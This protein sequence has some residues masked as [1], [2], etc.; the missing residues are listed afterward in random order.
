MSG[1]SVR[2]SIIR[3]LA[4]A[5]LLVM[6]S[7]C[8][9]SKHAEVMGTEDLQGA[10]SGADMSSEQGPDSDRGSMGGLAEEEI[11][12]RSAFEGGAAGDLMPFDVTEDRDRMGGMESGGAESGGAMSD[13]ERMEHD[14][15]NFGLSHVFFAYD[16]YDIDDAAVGVLQANARIL[17][18]Q[19]ENAD[20]LVEGHCDERGTV[21]YNLELGK[22]RAQAVKDYLVDLGV[23]E[24]NIRIVSYGKERP[25]CM[26]SRPDC[27]A[28]NRRG[29][30]LLMP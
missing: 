21:E 13:R 22:R 11:G 14:G 26:E 4:G 20:V 18:G 3:V 2:D 30:F 6:L 5:G 19:Y 23:R 27:W 17:K 10:S 16:K 25:F 8:Q 12:G 28:Q 9:T 7:A 15:T 1:V 29:H 24:S